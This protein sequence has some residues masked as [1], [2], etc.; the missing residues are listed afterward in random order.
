MAHGFHQKDK[1]TQ[2]RSRKQQPDPYTSKII[3]QRSKTR[4]EDEL[5]HAVRHKDFD[6]LED[7]DE[8]DV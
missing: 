4:C 7:Y 3:K 2:P 5:R 1:K 6:A 8:P